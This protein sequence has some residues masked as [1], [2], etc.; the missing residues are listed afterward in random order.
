MWLVGCAYNFCWE[1]DSLRV[2]APG[3]SGRQW[4]GRTPAMAAG[5]TARPWK[6]REVLGERQPPGRWEAP[7]RKP[8]RRRR[9]TTPL[10]PR[11]A[12]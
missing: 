2:A 1:H 6:L 3:E 5:L 8:R 10:T 7:R 11:S 12:P 9:R 4:L